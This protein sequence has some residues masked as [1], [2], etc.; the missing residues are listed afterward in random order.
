[1]FRAIRELAAWEMAAGEVSGGD[2]VGE[3]DAAAT[4]ESQL[5]NFGPPR[6]VLELLHSATLP[7]MGR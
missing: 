2:D 5:Q 7:T 1:M 3:V 4:E 6:A